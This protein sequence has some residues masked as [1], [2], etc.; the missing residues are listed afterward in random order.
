MYTKDDMEVGVLSFFETEW[1]GVINY[2]LRLRLR[3]YVDN[4]LYNETSIDS[5]TIFCSQKVGSDDYSYYLIHNKDL[6][7]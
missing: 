5:G 6:K 4:V 2:L 1:N 7:F 3:R